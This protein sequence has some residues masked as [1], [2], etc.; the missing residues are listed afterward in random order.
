MVAFGTNTVASVHFIPYK[1]TEIQV[2]T[3]LIN[4]YYANVQKFNIVINSLTLIVNKLYILQ[5]LQ[6][7]SKITNTSMFD[8][9]LLVGF[10]CAHNICILSYFAAELAFLVQAFRNWIFLCTFPTN[11][12]ET[13][14]KRVMFSKYVIYQ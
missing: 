10:I 14:Y 1:Q 9:C 11:R 3:I 7:L 12:R 6:H 8:S 13:L 4:Y 2:Y 5:D